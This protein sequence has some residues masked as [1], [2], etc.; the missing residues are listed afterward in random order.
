MKFI[1]DD[2][3]EDHIMKNFLNNRKIDNNSRVQYE[4]RIRSYCNFTG[5]TATELVEEAIKEQNNGVIFN[6]SKVKKYLY[7]YIDELNEKNKSENTIKA[8]LE[9]IKALYYDNDINIPNIKSLFKKEIKNPVLEELPT[10]EHVRKALKYC[11]FRDKA[12]IL[13][14]FTSGMSAA[15]VR[16]LTYGHFYNAI[17]QY[18][19][20]SGS[21]KFNIN[22]INHQLKNNDNIIGI[23]NLVNKTG[24]DYLTYNSSESNKA[25]ID[26]LLERNNKTFINSFEDPLFIA[27]GKK[28]EEHTFSFIYRRINQKA[29]FGYRNEKRIFL[30]SNIPCKM[31][32]ASLLNNGVELI[33]VKYMLGYKIDNIESSIYKKDPE[34][35]KREYLKCIKDISL[36]EV[37]EEIVTREKYDNLLQALN[38]EKEKN[39]KLKEYIKSQNIKN[40]GYHLVT[41]EMFE[42]EGQ[43]TYRNIRKLEDE[44]EHD[45]TD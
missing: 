31:F 7:S 32:S 13:L 37:K 44:I 24:M 6:D 1:K 28:I 10:K 39:K 29:G 2:I 33:A 9:T 38:D 26:Y 21:Y 5:K 34:A 17:K 19:N 22:K 3:L 42:K 43:Q 27:N 18:I 20:L 14:Q 25:L 45:D 16:N 36:K 15:N 41:N 11:N 4:I 30:T 12:I 8:H 23:W 35:L 40:S